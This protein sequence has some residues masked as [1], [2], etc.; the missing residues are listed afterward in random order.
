MDNVFSYNL[1]G[2]GNWFTRDTC[3]LPFGE[4]TTETMDPKKLECSQRC[5]GGERKRLWPYWPEERGARAFDNLSDHPTGETGA[6]KTEYS[7][8]TLTWAESYE[9]FF[10]PSL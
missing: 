2:R 4:Q 6:K 8:H 7:L 9:Y 1:P 3:V 10:L 5:H